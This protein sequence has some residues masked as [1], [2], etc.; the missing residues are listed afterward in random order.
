MGKEALGP[1]ALKA[2]QPARNASSFSSSVAPPINGRSLLLRR[3]GVFRAPLA[4]ALAAAPSAPPP[5]ALRFCLALPTLPGG[6]T[7][8]PMSYSSPCLPASELPGTGRG[9]F[10]AVLLLPFPPRC[11]TILA[12][13]ALS[14][15]CAILTGA[16]NLAFTLAVAGLS[17]PFVWLFKAGSLLGQPA[18]NLAFP[19]K[20]E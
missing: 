2:C 15:V 9:L 7:C 16:L 13:R 8:F 5:T 14:S 20:Q 6:T 18:L 19:Q 12:C 3:R 11:G 10:W 1:P 4:A 17:R